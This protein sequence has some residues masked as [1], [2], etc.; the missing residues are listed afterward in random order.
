MSTSLVHILT[1]I[2][3]ASVAAEKACDELLDRRVANEPR[4]YGSEDWSE[5]DH[6]DIERFCRQ[7]IG[8]AHELPI[9]YYAQY[10]NGWSVGNSFF[11]LLQWPDGLQRQ[12]CGSAFG[13]VYYSSAHWQSVRAQIEKRRR[14]KVYRSQAEDRWYLDHVKE[15][16]EHVVWL[17]S[18]F[19][20]IAISQC[21]APSR[22]DEEMVAA[23]QMPLKLDGQTGNT[24]AE[25]S[26]D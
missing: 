2:G 15:A 18:P 9:A 22:L 16:I 13:F 19:L 17:E 23:L 20:V 5:K 3:Q 12:V 11:H 4:A 14:T 21:L 6:L 8:A 26:N 25:W 7:L 24:L 10:I 1:V